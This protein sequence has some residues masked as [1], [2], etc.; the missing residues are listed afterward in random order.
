MAARRGARRARRRRGCATWD[1]WDGVRG[2]DGRRP[3][4]GR[5]VAAAVARERRR[6]AA[7]RLAGAAAVRHGAAAPAVRGATRAPTAR[8]ATTSARCSAGTSPR[9]EVLGGAARARPLDRPRARGPRAGAPARAA[10]LAAGASATGRFA[11]LL[12]FAPPGA[13]LEPRPPAG[14]AVDASLAFYPGATPLRALVAG[15]TGGLDDA[16]GTFG[17]GGAEDALRDRGGGDRRATRGS[18]SGRS[19][20]PPPSPTAATADAGRSPPDGSLPLGGSEQRPLAAAGAVRRAPG[21][22][23]RAAGTATRSSPLAARRRRTDGAAVTRGRL[24]RARRRGADRHRPPAGRRRRRRPA[25]PGARRRAR[26]RAA[27][28][29][30]C[31]RRRPRGR[32]R[33]A[34]A[35]GSGEPVGGRARRRDDPRPLCSPAAGARLRAL[36][37]DEDALPRA[38]WLE[39]RRGARAAAAARAA[40][41]PA[42]ARAPA[43]RRCTP[44]SATRP[45]RSGAGWPSASR[46]GRS[47]AAPATTSTPV[48]ARRRRAHERRALLE[49]L[50]RTDP[51]AARELLASTFAEE[52]WEDREAFVDALDDGLSDADEPFLEAALDDSRKPVRERRGAAARARCPRSRYAARMAERDAPLLRVED[53]ALVVDAARRARRGGASATASAAAA[54]ARSGSARCSPPTPL[55]DL[56]ASTLRRALPGRPTTSAPAVHAGWAAG[57]DGASATPTGRARCGRV[58]DDPSC[59]TCSRAPRPRRSRLAPTDPFAAALELPGPWGPR[60]LA[61][62]DRGDPGRREDGERA[63][64]RVAGYRL[65]P[66]LEPEAEALRD[67]GGRDV[68][69][70]VR[71]ARHPGC[72]AAGAVVTAETPLLRPHAEQLYADELAALER[73]DDRPRPPRWRL[74]PWAVTTYLLGGEADGTTITPKYV[75]RRRLVEL[76]VATLATDRALLLLGVPGHGQDVAVRAPRGGDQRRLHADRPGHG[77]HAARRRCATAG[78]T[79]GCSPRA[80]RATR[81]SPGPV[82]RAMAD[83]Q[84]RPR[85]GAD[86]HPVRRPGRADH[87]PVRE[88]AAD[89]G[90]RR[91]GPGRPGLQRDRHRQQPRP[92]R[93]RAL[94]RA[95]PPLQHRRPA[96]ARL[97]PTRR[98]R[99]SGCGSTRSA[100]RSSCRRRRPRS[101]RS[102]ASSRS[103]ASCAPA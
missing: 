94:Q 5:G 13:P 59:S 50:R 7:G 9:E 62:G 57:R 11:L 31:S 60:A 37:E 63:R 17:T 43:T 69:N 35:R 45:A 18:T 1:E 51:A 90:A 74:S 8:C 55:D 25:R 86:A 47:C 4:A 64:R 29:T 52:T 54:G 30:G 77:G 72:H 73:A 75:G 36:L 24:G 34:P 26:R 70:A 67:L 96:A 102:A 40:A 12:D 85:R 98:S 61:R 46:A 58:V 56:A 66:A 99:S 20:S 10:H 68:W 48:W 49:R 2:A 23:V 101:R 16:P 80:R 53:G 92:R 95:A 76:A 78:T 33:G 79:R 21:L 3:G 65:D 44:R 93:Q 41:R 19:R 71:R 81:S 83:G 14:A 32:S 15:E 84:A 38:E 91:R 42:R 82:M 6:R 88:D 22:R 89:P 27:P 103:S 100:A 87:D 97:A 39:L 28:R